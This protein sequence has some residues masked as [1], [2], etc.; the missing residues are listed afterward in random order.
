MVSHRG[1]NL[2]FLNDYWCWTSYFHLLYCH[3]QI[4]F[5]EI[6]SK[7]FVHLNYLISYYGI[8]RVLKNTYFGYRSFIKYVTRKEFLWVCSLCFHFLNNVIQRK[9][10]LHFGEIKFSFMDYGFYPVSN[11]SLPDK[12]WQRTKLTDNF[13]LEIL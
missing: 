2:H 13:L 10:V 1:I 3:L 12:K 5:G 9:K 11:N 7:F 4:I 6:A 8:L